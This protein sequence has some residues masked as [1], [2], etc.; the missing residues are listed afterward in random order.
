MWLPV[1]SILQYVE[2]GRQINL[3]ISNFTISNYSSLFTTIHHYSQLFVTIR[4]YSSL[5]ATIRHFSL[6]ATWVF[7]TP[8][9]IRSSSYQMK[10][11]ISNK[12]TGREKN[13]LRV[14]HRKLRVVKGK[15]LSN[16]DPIHEN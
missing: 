10:G 2:F 12:V 5:F 8:H 6:F 7:Q 14:G 1:A 11:K 4:N 13:L 16:E 9:V 3:H 15:S